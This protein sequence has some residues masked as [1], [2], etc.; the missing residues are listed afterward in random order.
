MDFP[1]MIEMIVMM[2]I[3]C[4]ADH[5][6]QA[7]RRLAL[8]FGSEGHGSSHGSGAWSISTAEQKPHR[9][10]SWESPTR[11]GHMLDD[12]RGVRSRDF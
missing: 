12:S 2:M 8:R 7:L 11:V 9:K 3:A 1:D 4:A 10:T 6:L 5:M